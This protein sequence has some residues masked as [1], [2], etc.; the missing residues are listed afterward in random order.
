M[1]ES[2]NTP[3]ILSTAQFYIIMPFLI[4]LGVFLFYGTRSLLTW[5]K[6]RKQ[7][8]ARNGHALTMEQSQ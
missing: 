6:Q 1:L 7:T 5:Q 4:I 3:F 8:L 2:D